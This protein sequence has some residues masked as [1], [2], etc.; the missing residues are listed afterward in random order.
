[1]D[2]F[3]HIKLIGTPENLE[4]ILYK[5]LA[6]A[7]VHMVQKDNTT[8]GKMEISIDIPSNANNQ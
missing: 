8:E 1:M 6:E 2:N 5:N 3:I 4:S 7:M